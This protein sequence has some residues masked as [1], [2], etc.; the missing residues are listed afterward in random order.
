TA[1]VTP[2]AGVTDPIP[3]N[4]SATDTDAL[5]GT[6]DLRITIT[7]G[8]TTVIPGTSVTYTIVVTN[9]GPSNVIGASITDTFPATLLGVTYT[10]VQ[11]GG[12]TGFTASGSGNI[13]DT[14]NMPAASTITYTVTATV[15]PAA[16]G[17]LTDTASVAPPA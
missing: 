15:S 7:D 11:T 6:A 2:P 1:T 13:A 16:T 3:G 10:A 17:T 4:N 9:G 12:S 8:V 14:V 5:A